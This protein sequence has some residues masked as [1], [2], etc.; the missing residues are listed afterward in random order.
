MKRLMLWIGLALSVILT[1]CF[2]LSV[3]PYYFEN[4][5][6]FDKGLLGKWMVADDPNDHEIWTFETDETNSYKFTMVSR[7]TNVFSAHLF[8]LKD[9]LFIDCL[10]TSDVDFTVTMPLH[11]LAEVKQIQPRLRLCLFGEKAVTDW[12]TKNPRSIR[13]VMETDPD[14]ADN[15]SS[16]AVLTAD[17]KDLQ[18]FFMQ[19]VNDTNF[20]M[21]AS[22]LKQ[23]DA[24]T[25]N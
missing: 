1:G 6:V 10:K 14:S 16:M 8:K 18:R 17:T 2:G 5:V 22:D 15:K 20:F 3:Y 7:E 24:K 23:A 13:H 25:G 12:V 21:P 19:H 4:Q 9:R 11:L